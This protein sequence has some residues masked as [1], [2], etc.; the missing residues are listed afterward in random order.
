PKQHGE[1]QAVFPGRCAGF[2]AAVGERKR[3]SRI[4]AS[5]Y[6]SEVALPSGTYYWR[7]RAVNNAGQFSN[8]SSSRSFRVP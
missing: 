6:T 2:S 3:G 5:Q 1:W 7:V 8:W 4:A